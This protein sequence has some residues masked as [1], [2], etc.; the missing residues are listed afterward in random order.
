MKRFAVLTSVLA[1]AA[2]GGGSGGGIVG[3]NSG[4]IKPT[5][6]IDETVRASNLVVASNIDNGT[7]RNKVIEN[8]YSVAG[9][10]LPNIGDLHSSANVAASSQTRS[11]SSRHGADFS[12]SFVD[13]MYA[14][15]N[16]WLHET[17]KKPQTDAEYEQYKHA[18]ILAGYVKNE[19]GN[20]LFDGNNGMSIKDIIDAI[21][22]SDAIANIR[23][24]A[25]NI[26]EE[27]GTFKQ[28]RIEDSA[29]FFIP[30]GGGE[31]KLVFR[32]DDKNQINRVTY[33]QRTD[34]GVGI[35]FDLD[36]T[37]FTKNSYERQ[38]V[39]T[40]V[41][42]INEIDFAD[43]NDYDE[44]GDHSIEIETT[45]ELSLAEIK[46]KMKAQVQ[47]EYEN[48][49]FHSYHCTTEQDYNDA[50]AELERLGEESP[51]NDRIG[52]MV[53]EIAARRMR[54]SLLK[55]IDNWE[56]DDAT[57]Q[58]VIF[59]NVHLDIETYGKDVGLAYSN[60][61]KMFR[62]TQRKE[63]NDEFYQNRENA[64]TIIFGGYADNR[65]EKIT[66]EM[67]FNGMAVGVVGYDIEKN[68]DDEVYDAGMINIAGDATLHIDVAN[69]G[70]MTE[71]LNISFA[72]SN[73]YDVTVVNDAGDD[74]GPTIT[75]TDNTND[76]IDENYKLLGN[77]TDG[78]L[79]IENFTTGATM[80]TDNDGITGSSEGAFGVQYYGNNPNNPTEAV[81][82]VA[83]SEGEP[84]SKT[85]HAT[86]KNI[87]FEAG[88]GLQKDLTK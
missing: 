26:Y 70:D 49:R 87:M 40:W 23:N 32:V 57:E 14:N 64:Q 42:A 21:W 25:E 47:Y 45:E 85:N 5:V 22:N 31:S 37:D 46:A 80:D 83:Y 52:Q 82:F 10:D 7:K 38:G 65:I 81:G 41:Y 9:A 74:N 71:T 62:K 4:D 6:G 30:E 28:F 1:L 20:L 15:M 58:G 2:C 67:D 35:V 34:S 48:S 33:D 24:K 13:A 72:D 84:E 54:D 76:S 36:R 75:F 86:T 53:Q 56:S 50:L 29:M 63:Q 8:N 60:F 39:K 77:M 68:H 17:N 61:G 16:Y 59:H 88:F 51:S 19:L 73:W 78:V 3:N 66:N 44:E 43:G 79:T 11:A 27:L 12:N 69:N 18:L 55:R